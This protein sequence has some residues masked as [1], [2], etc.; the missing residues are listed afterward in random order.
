MH[1]LEYGNLDRIVKNVNETYSLLQNNLSKNT[2]RFEATFLINDFQKLD[3]PLEDIFD[4]KFFQLENR[5]FNTIKK[6]ALSTLELPY[7]LPY[8]GQFYQEMKGSLKIDIIN[9]IEKKVVLFFCGY[10]KFI[11]WEKISN[12]PNTNA[13]FEK[14]FERSEKNLEYMQRNKNSKLLELYNK[15]SCL[16]NRIINNDKNND[17]IIEMIKNKTDYLIS[18]KSKNTTQINFNSYMEFLLDIWGEEVEDLGNLEERIQE[19]NFVAM[20]TCKYRLLDN[21]YYFENSNQLSVFGPLEEYNENEISQNVYD[22]ENVLEE[23]DQ[24]LFFV[25]KKLLKF[26]SNYAKCFN[27]KED[28]IEPEKE[29]I[30]ELVKHFRELIENDVNCYIHDKKRDLLNF[31]SLFDEIILSKNNTKFIRDYLIKNKIN[32]RFGTRKNYGKLRIDYNN[33]IPL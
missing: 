22:E 3:I 29:K 31:K 13:E 14:I 11:G 5:I 28:E 20:F 25:S 12:N 7:D 15:K 17:L 30:I 10:S 8:L 24:K 16:Y 9:F 32:Y 27:N 26:Y 21:L 23:E 4:I 1:F 33:L 2:F 6:G 19:L 18:I